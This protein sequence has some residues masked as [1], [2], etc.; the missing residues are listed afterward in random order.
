[1]PPDTDFPRGWIT[2]EEPSELELRDLRRIVIERLRGVVYTDQHSGRKTVIKQ[3]PG[4]FKRVLQDLANCGHD[5]VICDIPTNE[6]EADP[7]SKPL[8]ICLV[9]DDGAGVLGLPR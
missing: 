7:N 6:N 3:A 2:T 9:C 1:M 5:H 4:R 8:R